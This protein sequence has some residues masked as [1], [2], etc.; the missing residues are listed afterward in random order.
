[1]NKLD[2]ME[3]I[4]YNCILSVIIDSLLDLYVIARDKQSKCNSLAEFWFC[5]ASM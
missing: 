4:N 2:N 3:F 1:L 5:E